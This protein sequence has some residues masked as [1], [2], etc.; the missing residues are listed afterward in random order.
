MSKIIPF[1]SKEIIYRDLTGI[2]PYISMC[3]HKKI[4]Y[5]FKFTHS[6]LDT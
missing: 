5:I 3:G 6:K 4:I 2:I 1:V